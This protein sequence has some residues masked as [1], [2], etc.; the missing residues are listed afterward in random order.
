MSSEDIFLMDRVLA[1]SARD[2]VE[3]V[4]KRLVDYKMVGVSKVSTNLGDFVR[5]IPRN[6]EVVTHYTRSGTD[7]GFY[8][9]VALIPKQAQGEN[10]YSTSGH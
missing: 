2:Y 8:V 3:S 9:G 4:G 6:A 1:C 10:K 7:V 5:N